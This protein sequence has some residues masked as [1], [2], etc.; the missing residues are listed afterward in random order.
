MCIMTTTKPQ[1]DKP[2]ALSPRLAPRPTAASAARAARNAMNR[3]L[4]LPTQRQSPMRSPPSPS[5]SKIRTA[6]SRNC[7][8]SDSK[9]EMKINRNWDSEVQPP[10]PV[11]DE[12]PVKHE[13]EPINFTEEEIDVDQNNTQQVTDNNADDLQYNSLDSFGLVDTQ[14][15]GENSMGAIL[16]S[17]TEQAQR[18][19]PQTPVQDRPQTPK[20]VSSRP[21]TPKITSRSGTPSFST[22]RHSTPVSRPN[23]PKRH[24]PITRPKTPSMSVNSL[25]RP[26]TPVISHN[27]PPS[28]KDED[29]LKSSYLAKQKQFHLMKKELDLKQQAVLE[30]FDILQNLRQQML[31]EGISAGGE[32][33]NE[34]VVFKVSDWAPNEVSQLC[35]DAA[36]SSATD[37][38]EE[39][40]TTASPIDEC[41]LT[42]VY[43]KVVKIPACFAELCLQAFSA[44][45]ELIDWIKKLIEKDDIVGNEALDKIAQYNSQGLELCESLRNL[46]TQADDALDIVTS[47]TKRVCKERSTLVA[48]GEALVREVAQLRLDLDTNVLKSDLRETDIEISKDLEETRRE[49]EEERAAKLALKDKLAMTES[50]LRQTR[51]RVSKMD[52]QLREAEASIA[53]LTGTVKTLEDQSR[54][55]EVQLEA[56]ARKLKESLKTGEVASNHLA[57]KRD[58]L[59][60]EVNNLREENK[61]MTMQ[62]KTEE[63]E[64]NKKLKEVMTALEEE[65]NLLQRE[66]EQKQNLES[67]LQES[68]KIIED[69]QAKVSELENKQN[70]D[71]PTER[72][73]DLWAELQATKDI[74]R[75]AEEE[76]KTCK[77]E[78]VRFLETFTKIADSENKLGMQQ[79][80]T[81]ELLNKED[82]IG[83]MQIQIRDLTKNNKLFEQKVIQY[84]QYFRDLQ[85]H[86]RASAKCQETEN[87][88]TYQDLQEEIM[89]MKMSL[90]DAVHRNEEL[91]ELL[92]QKDQLL[93]HQDKTSRAQVREE[94]IDMLKDKETEQSRELT[95]LQQDLE[96]R[97]KIVDEVN[98]QIAAKADEIQELFST[99][100]NKQQQ[101]HRL[102]K[103][104]LALEEQQRRAQAQRTRH[105]E[106]IAALEH[107]LAAGGNRRE[108]KFLFF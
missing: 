38:A 47:L 68:Q 12:I 13:V 59:Q 3:N 49:L 61:L 66:T 91:S 77:S 89:N 45:Q 102:E 81:A 85:A 1:K 17:E 4:A 18:K 107:E 54:Q 30:V 78:K 103:I 20:S 42:E 44:R 35:R 34:L 25:Q 28:I 99:L 80:L 6:I 65:K 53:S 8:R 106:K 2:H 5:S 15:E 95:E 87:G 100:E 9:T 43:S 105:E 73:M 83:K 67:S 101:I 58:S 32:G 63:Q 29:C 94:L 84:E 7:P 98:K 82:I 14:N 10:V 62:H 97:M 55:R 27:T 36:A 71:L 79:K 46:K 23:T 21:Q 92:I 69:L 76:I 88:I 39:L 11:F 51:L 74:L 60:I 72:E 75:G 108:R 37:G 104:V 96:H 50:H 93:E 19:R 64:L 57:Q 31:R 48:V 56:R 40:L 41:A 16:D 26:V 33:Q 24:T 90:L 70:P 52:R 86:N 22:Q